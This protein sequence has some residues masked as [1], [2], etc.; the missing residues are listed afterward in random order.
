[1]TNLLPAWRLPELRT[2]GHR[3]GCR[4]WTPSHGL[5]LRYFPHLHGPEQTRPTAVPLTPVQVSIHPIGNHTDYTD[6]CELWAR[7][8]DGRHHE[9]DGT[10][11]AD[12]T[13][14]W[15]AAWDA[16]LIGLRVW[17]DLHTLRVGVF[18]SAVRGDTH[19]ADRLYEDGE[20]NTR[21][22]RLRL[23]AVHVLPVP[24][25]VVEVLDPVAEYHLFETGDV[26][27]VD[28]ECW[29]NDIPGAWVEIDPDLLEI[30]DSAAAFVATTLSGLLTPQQKV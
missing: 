29:A 23:A 4:V 30:Q 7:T 15:E 24:G 1:M 9:L 17:E 25:D 16:G 20:G 28:G 13:R 2:G 12:T 8:E 19:Q 21:V 6:G 5:P 11:Y 27:C 10:T 18:F 26:I 22:T 3:G 14:A